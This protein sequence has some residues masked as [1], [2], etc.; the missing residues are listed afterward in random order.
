MLSSRS[1]VQSGTPKLVFVRGVNRAGITL[2]NP[3]LDLFKGW[4]DDCLKL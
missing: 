1:G 3:R 4:I 2:L